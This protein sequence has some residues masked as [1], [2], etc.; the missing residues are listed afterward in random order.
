MIVW[1]M[2]VLLFEF[3]LVG[4]VMFGLLWGVFF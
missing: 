1:V 4:F 2:I 3:L